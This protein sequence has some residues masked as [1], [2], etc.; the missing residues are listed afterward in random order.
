M[1][2]EELLWEE[3]RNGQ[4]AGV[5]RGVRKGRSEALKDSIFLIW[6]RKG[7]LPP[8]TVRRIRK[9]KDPEVLLQW[10]YLSA[11]SDSPEDFCSRIEEK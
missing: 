8:G 5:R 10:V 6:N 9:E 11:Q 2:L 3:R 4:K 7:G 1:R